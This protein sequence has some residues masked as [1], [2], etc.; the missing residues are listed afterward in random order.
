MNAVTL[1]IITQNCNNTNVHLL[2]EQI[3]ILWSSHTMEYCS[4]TKKN[5]LQIHT[6]MWM[7]VK[8]V[9]VSE[10]KK[11]LMQKTSWIIPCIWH[12]VKVTGTERTVVSMVWGWR[13]D[14]IQSDMM[15]KLFWGWWQWR[16]SQLWW[17]LRDYSFVKTDQTIHLSFTIC[18]FCLN[19]PE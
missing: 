5:K 17:L 13:E 6:T 1:L 4:T 14:W 16:V 10:K 9:M 8:W 11:S 15:G 19:K 12:F 2:G 18:K 7:N 3:S